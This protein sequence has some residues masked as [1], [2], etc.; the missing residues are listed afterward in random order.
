MSLYLI[1]LLE[2]LGFMFLAFNLIQSVY[3]F[4][5]TLY[6]LE[7]NLS[8]CGNIEFI[9]YPKDWIVS[10]LNTIS[11]K[12]DQRQRHHTVQYKEPRS[13]ELV[14]TALLHLRP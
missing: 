12:V 10:F 8:F 6:S 9:K 11:T 5:Y 4:K 1:D 14:C 7:H 13:G 3:F 2:L